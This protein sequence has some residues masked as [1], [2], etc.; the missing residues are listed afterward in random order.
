MLWFPCCQVPLGDV[1]AISCE[2][3]CTSSA[4][5]LIYSSSHVRGYGHA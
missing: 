2:F 3:R 4:E 5:S 1:G